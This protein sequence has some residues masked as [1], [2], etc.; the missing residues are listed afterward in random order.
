MQVATDSCNTT[1]IQ[2]F[3]GGP[4]AVGQAGS[5]ATSN[6][7]EGRTRITTGFSPEIYFAGICCFGASHVWSDCRVWCASR[8]WIR[9]DLCNATR[10]LRRREA[11]RF[12]SFEGLPEGGPNDAAWK[13]GQLAVPL[14]VA[15][16]NLAEFTDFCELIPGWIP[17]TFGCVADRR[18]RLIHVDV[19]LEVPTRESL[20]F[21]ILA[22]ST[23]HC[24]LSTIT[25]FTVARARKRQ[26]MSSW[27]IGPRH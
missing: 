4:T 1:F 18:F 7:T 24:S 21:S 9:S 17:D 10:Y 19:D 11:L 2:K 26:R 12:D 8:H 22:R 16:A 25:D 27:R 23:V 5:I 14:D 3:N 6:Q 13:K 20:G 15:R